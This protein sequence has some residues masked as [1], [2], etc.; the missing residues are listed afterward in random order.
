MTLRDYEEA[1]EAI[2]AH[3]E[4]ADFAGPRDE[5]LVEAA[6]RA[7]GVRFPPSYRRFLL[8]FGAGSFDGHEIYGVLD[9]DFESSGVPDAVWVT[10]SLRDEDPIPADLIVFYATGDGEHLCV[11]SGSVDTPV[12][13]IWPG[14]DEEP[15]VVAPDF[16]VWLK[17]IV[18]YGS[19]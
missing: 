6:E 2:V 12:V 13:A 14:S 9:D 1:R 11:R 17:E 18:G 16:G 10:R 5:K 3:P 15:E 8:D 7:L 4:L 19:S